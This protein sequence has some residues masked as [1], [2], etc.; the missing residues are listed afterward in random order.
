VTT[1]PEGGDQTFL[2]TPFLA[3]GEAVSAPPALLAGPF[4]WIV[5]ANLFGSLAFWAFYGAV[6]W[7]ATNRFGAEQADMAVLGAALSVP[8]IL[9]SLIQGLA[10]D[11]WSPKWLLVIGY[12]ALLTAVPLALVAS[13]LPWL[14]ASSFL[15]GGAFATIEPSR[16]ALTGLLVASDRLVQANGAI[17]TSFQAALIVGSL[18]GGWLLDAFGADAVYGLA[19]TSAVLPVALLLR[20]PDV[21]PHGERPTASVRDLRAGAATA[22]GLPALRILLVVTTASWLLINVF[23]LLEPLYVK[24]VLGR[25]DAAL[26][27]LWAA[28]GAGALV[29]AISVTRARHLGGKEAA[30]VCIGVGLVGAGIFAYTVGG[31]YGLALIASAVSGVGFALFFPPLLALIQRVVPEEQRGRVTGV[32]VALQESAGLTSSLAI[33]V[34]GSLVLVQPTLIAAGAAIALMGI[35]GFRVELQLRRKEVSPD[36]HPAA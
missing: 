4:R 10:V 1:E 21:R 32:F 36:A 13:S 14:W 7:E 2:G 24:D 35:V 12:A 26:L 6:F 23:F 25:G 11:R 34:L 19:I 16:S 3:Q 18:G 29:G 31:R 15:V 30:L 33:L 9:G 22:W 20:T 17:A 28:H 27:Y 5:L 8:F